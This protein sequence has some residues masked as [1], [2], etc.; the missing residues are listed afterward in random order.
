M[1]IDEQNQQIVYYSRLLEKHFDGKL[2]LSERRELAQWLW[3]D[4]RNRLLYMKIK[5]GSSLKTYYDLWKKIDPEQEYELLAERCPGLQRKKVKLFVRLR[6]VAAVLVLVLGTAVWYK[7]GNVRKTSELEV[8][9]CDEKVI[10]VLKTSSGEIFRLNGNNVRVRQEQVGGLQIRDSL[11][12]LVCGQIPLTDSSAMHEL[13]IPRG[14]EYKLVL[15]DGTMVWLNSESEIHFPAVFGATEREITLWGEAYLEVMP[16]AKRPFRVKAGEGIIEVLGTSF[17]LR[18]YPDEQQWSTVLVNGSV[19]VKYGPNS[20]LLEPGKEAFLKNGKLVKQE[21]EPDKELAW[22]RG[23]FIFEHDRLEKVAKELSRW[24]NVEFR[25][26]NEKLKEY[27]FTGQ[28]SRD[29]GVDSILDLM[30][31]MNV[32]KFEKTDDYVLIKEK[33]GNY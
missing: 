1:N 12:E 17:G 27:V 4:R 30:E 3:R 23:L 9:P 6:W 18:I 24:Y 31:R 25:F 29:I 15:A 19:K 7:Y 22:V 21:C 20:L 32:V 2:S 16:D 33:A 13:V 28:V 11:K 5:S 14:G 26:E 8:L 10:A